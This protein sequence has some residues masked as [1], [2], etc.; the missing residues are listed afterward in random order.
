[1]EISLEKER[2]I[3]S[4]IGVTELIERTREVLRSPIPVDEI[5]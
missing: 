4:F 1:M 5:L 2:E 3:F